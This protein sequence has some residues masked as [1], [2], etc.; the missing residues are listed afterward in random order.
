M[1]TP[2]WKI[3]KEKLNKT[4]LTRYSDFINRN[5]KINSGN[6]FNKIW[7]WSID[8]PKLFW[9]SIWEFTKVKGSLGNVLLEESDIFFK[10]KFFPEGRLNYAENLLKKDNKDDAI[11]FRSENGFRQTQSWKELNFKVGKISNWM[12]SVGIKK[13]DRIAAYLLIFQKLF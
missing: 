7:K 1:E 10:N 4:N 13:G 5:Y 2:I 3:S 9:K 6:N 8:N 11:I 12:I